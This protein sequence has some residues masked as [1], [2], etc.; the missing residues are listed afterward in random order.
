[1]LGPLD[2]E[3]RRQTADDDLRRQLDLAIG[4]AIVDRVYAEQILA[5]PVLALDGHG[6]TPQQLLLLQQIRAV[7]VRDLAR[8]A[9]ALFWPTSPAVTTGGRLTATGDVPAQDRHQPNARQRAMDPWWQDEEK[10]AATAL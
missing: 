2:A 5:N 6:C 10:M 1:M 8:Q 4:R 7:T 3:K 9:L